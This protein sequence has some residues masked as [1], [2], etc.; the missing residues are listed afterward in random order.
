[1]E[2]YLTDEE[3]KNSRELAPKTFSFSQVELGGEKKI[4][5]NNE[6]PNCKQNG[7]SKLVDQSEA[8]GSSFSFGSN[9][10]S[11][12]Q[13]KSGL[14]EEIA[15]MSEEEQTELYTS[16]FSQTDNVFSPTSKDV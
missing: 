11:E 8:R 7:S 12:Q 3:L 10:E 1:M 5:L 2:R 9:N 16:S 15:G 6:Q 13:N 4:F 14:K